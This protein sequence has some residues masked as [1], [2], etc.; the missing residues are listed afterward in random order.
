V[1][2]RLYELSPEYAA[3]AELPMERPEEGDY[4][5]EGYEAV[6]PLF[7]ALAAVNAEAKVCAQ[8]EAEAAMLLQHAQ[9]IELRAQARLNRVKHLERFMGMLLEGF[10][11]AKVKDAF[12][13]VWLQ[14]SSPAVEVTDEAAVPA[15]FKRATLTLPVEELPADLA[16]RA[17]VAVQKGAI[18]EHIRETGEVPAGVEWVTD[19]RHLRRRS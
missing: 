12:V 4:A 6:A 9:Q 16:S 1:S 18:A 3:L 17:T 8:L 14:K 11:V 13:S 10:G 2:A 19:R 7:D 15:A 5:F